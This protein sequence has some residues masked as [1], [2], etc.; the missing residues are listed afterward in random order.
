MIF[1]NLFIYPLEMLVDFFFVFFHESFENIGIS[2]LGISIVINMLSLPLYNKAELLQRK[3]RDL[4]MQMTPGIN[5]I[6][7][8]FKGDEQYMIL[9]TYYRQNHYHPVYALRS[10]VSLMI[11]VPFFIAAYHY[12]SNLPQLQGVRFL[13][14]PDLGQPDGMLIFGALQVNVLPILM[15]LINIIAGAVY[16]KGLPLRDKVQ[17]N[18]MAL[19]FLILLYTSPA[20]LVLYW[21]CNNLFSLVKNLFYR[22]RHPM[23]WLYL[24]CAVTAVVLSATILILHPWAPLIK[25]LLVIAMALG[26]CLIPIFLRGFSKV[27]YRY[28]ARAYASNSTRNQ[29]F[30]LSIL[31]LW[32]LQ[33]IVVPALLIQSSPPEFSYLGVVNHPLAFLFDTATKYAGLYL[34]WVLLF[35]VLS[36]NTLRDILALIF[37]PLAYI[38]LMNILVFSGSYGYISPVLLFDNPGL[39]NP[40]TLLNLSSIGSAL[41]IFLVCL[42]ISIKGRPVILRHILSILLLGTLLTSGVIAVKI[43]SEYAMHTEILKELEQQET[44]Q[45]GK[46]DYSLS[47][48]GK[49]VVYVF[50][51]RAIGSYTGLFFQEFQEMKD[52]FQ[53]F[54][55]YPNTVS[56]GHNTAN[57]GP[58]MLAGYEYSPDNLNARATEKMVDK[59]NEALLVLPRLFAESGYSVVYSDPPYSNYRL[60]GDYQPFQPY[61]EISVKQL[62]GKQTIRY[63]QEHADVLKWDPSATS[64]VLK[65]R[66]PVFSLL[67][68]ALPVMR[69]SMYD[70]GR[71]MRMGFTAQS[72]DAFLDS[73]SQLYYLPDLTGCSA[74]GDTFTIIAN[75]TPHEPVLLNGSQYEPSDVITNL[76]NPFAQAGQ[77]E[78]QP[79]LA[80]YQVNAATLIQLGKWLEHLQDEGVY[81]NT[82]IIIVSDHGYTVSTPYFHDFQK[83][84]LEYALYNPLLLVKD[85]S[86]SGSLQVDEQFMTNADAAILALEGLDIPMINPFTGEDMKAWIKKDVVS[87]FQG[88]GANF[89]GNQIQIDYGRSYTIKNDIRIESNWGT[90]IP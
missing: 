14:I 63:K 69:E 21:T 46:A 77:G 65:A 61:P 64:D 9:S 40:S 56:F 79:E 74:T 90:L 33:G 2:I 38:A 53:G 86:E 17:L 82:R 29:V 23:K 41:C 57:A 47:R 4:R 15:T 49:N 78:F 11:Q 32:V 68:T 28:L 84:G 60:V 5:R 22:L 26:V 89:T 7:Q 12:L 16:T 44:L 62:I 3:E 45:K 58:A 75:E 36:S 1:Y 67:R 25:R 66:L 31:L 54:T 80:T 76:Y 18:G 87:V 73:Y 43:H 72:I 35:Y 37:P 27:Y 20:G 34:V 51:D 48:Q 70:N 71:Y 42:L 13:G 6:K 39:L 55:Y 8:A 19:L 30:I 81:D 83:N 88:G 24:I 85:F 52:V 50:L 59:H 10:S